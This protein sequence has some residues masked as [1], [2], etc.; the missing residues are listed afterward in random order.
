MCLSESILVT[1]CHLRISTTIVIDHNWSHKLQIHQVGSTLYMRLQYN[2]VSIYQCQGWSE[3]G[4]SYLH[5]LPPS[6]C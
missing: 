2:T 1:I 5:L 4:A 3:A 6:G